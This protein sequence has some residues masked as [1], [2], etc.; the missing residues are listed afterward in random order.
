[1]QSNMKMNL[2]YNYTISHEENGG[3]ARDSTL[4]GFFSFRDTLRAVFHV[5]I[6]LWTI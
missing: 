6:L 2:E 3:K 5:D 4:D 1:M